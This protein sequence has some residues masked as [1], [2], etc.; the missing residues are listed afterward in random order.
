MSDQPPDDPTQRR[1]EAGPPPG[2]DPTRNWAPPGGST[3]RPTWNRLPQTPP[4]RPESQGW[5]P[6]PSGPPAGQQG[7][8]GPGVQPEW[9]PPPPPPDW[10]TQ[11]AAWAQPGGWAGE[12]PGWA[13]AVGPPPPPGRA[14]ALLRPPA[15]LAIALVALVAVGGIGWWLTQ[16]ISSEVGDL[17]DLENF[18]D[19]VSA[20]G[21]SEVR[22]IYA[23][24][25]RVDDFTVTD[26]E[27]REDY[28]DDFEVRAV[29]TYEGDDDVHAELAAQVL[30]GG[31]TIAT[32]TLDTTVA[33]RSGDTRTLLFTTLD[34]YDPA[35]DDVGFL[36][37]GLDEAEIEALELDQTV[38]DFTF[39][40]V[41]VS[42]DYAD[43][44]Q[45][46]ATITYDG[47]A[48][49]DGVGLIAQIR[50]NGETV[51]ELSAAETFAPGES[52]S[53]TFIGYDDYDDFDEV[54]FDVALD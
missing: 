45:V 31:S 40:D 10:G 42:Q 44:F 2:E 43:D 15:L 27:V 36:V 9:M 48:Q 34:D 17:G 35:H 6:P 4:Q 20:G 16:R 33:F 11:P 38:D 8:S 53:V 39:S 47:A 32:A 51:S 23:G 28:A 37:E 18:L 25:Y 30:D 29:V 49:V 41:R 19:E 26:V 21:T 3:P 12:D 13:G 52:Y 14:P 5:G 46:D 7:S 22:E 50:E 24:P 54:R 1:E